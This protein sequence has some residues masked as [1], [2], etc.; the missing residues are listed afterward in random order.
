MNKPLQYDPPIIKDSNTQ[1]SMS[2]IWLHG[3]GAD[4]HDFLPIIELL[5]LTNYRFILPHA[6]VQAVTINNGYHMRAWYDIYGLT[7]GSQEDDAGIKASQT[8]I[9]SL[10]TNELNKGM[11]SNQIILAGFSQGGAIALQ[12]ALRYTSPLAG[13]VALSTYLPLKGKLPSEKASTNQQVPIF[14]AHGTQDEVIS[15]ETNIVSRDA[16]LADNYDVQW[17]QYPMAHTVS[18]DVVQDIRTFLM[19]IET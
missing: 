12:T 1:A 5:G 11:R 18:L 19:R 3:L 14:M 6:P 13:V 2:V 9:E 16:L 15:L 4:G 7:V 10:I 17:L 8:Y